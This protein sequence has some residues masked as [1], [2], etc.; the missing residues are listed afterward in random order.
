MRK[1]TFLTVEKDRF[2]GFR[3][4]ICSN[5]YMKELYDTL[6]YQTIIDYYTCCPPI[7]EFE[8]SYKKEYPN[9]EQY[10][11]Q[12]DSVLNELISIQPDSL[13]SLSFVKK[14]TRNTLLDDI[15]VFHI[16]VTPLKGTVEQFDF[17]YYFSRKIDGETTIDDI[18]SSIVRSGRQNSPVNKE[19]VI[20]YMGEL[21][22]DIHANTSSEE[23]LRDYNFIY[24]ITNVRYK[25]R[26]WGD[27][28]ISVK[29]Y[30][31]GKSVFQRE[32]AIEAIIPEFIDSNY[33][34][35]DTYLLETRGEIQRAKYPTLSTLFLMYDYQP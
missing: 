15:P 5:D 8:E 2:L 32:S 12:T 19:T 26:N 20:G 6:K 9:A 23:L 31:A 35:F 28:P 22:T 7:A 17:E 25:G 21:W 29:Y 10:K 3:D 33:K 14:T 18:P 1:Y 4:W 16:R 27:L 30:I 34:S 24:E 11:K 13:V